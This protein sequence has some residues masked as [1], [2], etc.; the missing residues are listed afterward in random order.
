MT[1]RRKNPSG[2]ALFLVAAG[3]AALYLLLR[4]KAPATSSKPTGGDPLG[5]DPVGSDPAGLVGAGTCASVVITTATDSLTIRAD[6]TTSSR[7]V[8]TVAKGATVAVDRSVT[9]QSANGSTTWYHL[10]DG[11]GFI[12]GGYCRCV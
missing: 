2:S 10:A 9:G 11:R 1:K 6:A 4:K 5:V 7:A 3:G 8:G 12:A